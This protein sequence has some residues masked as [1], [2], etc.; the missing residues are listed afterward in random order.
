MGLLF[1]TVIVGEISP[2]H[3]LNG[4]ILFGLAS[5]RLI[6]DKDSHRQQEGTPLETTVSSYCMSLLIRPLLIA[7]LVTYYLLSV[8]EGSAFGQG[9]VPPRR[10]AAECKDSPSGEFANI[11]FRR[12]GGRTTKSKVLFA[13]GEI[14]IA[15][16][17]QG[18]DLKEYNTLKLNPKTRTVAGLK[19]DPILAQARTF[20]FEHWRD[21]KK[22]YLSL[23]LS[24][25]DATSTSHIFIEQDETG[26]W[27]IAW[28]IIR[29]V[30]EIDDLPT[31]YSVRWVR[32][33]GY[34]EPG[35]PLAEGQKPDP[36]EN[37]LEFR[38]HC[39]DIEQTL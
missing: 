34:R 16:V 27:R 26:R 37:R 30:G 2:Y 9:R 20:L 3:S 19:D 25:V 33:A 38:D 32:P 8:L 14:T 15:N 7:S 12:K 5:R 28:R 29:D 22:A 31:Y 17:E 21:H 23:T 36:V 10:E 24:S 35:T 39:G 18:R 6:C 1:R 4:S 13:D 11:R